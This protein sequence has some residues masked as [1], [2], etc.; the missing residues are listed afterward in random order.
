MIPLEPAYLR[1]EP[2]GGEPPPW[3][4]CDTGA[5]LARARSWPV[6]RAGR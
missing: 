3:L 1:I 4:D 6:T 5:D 2:A